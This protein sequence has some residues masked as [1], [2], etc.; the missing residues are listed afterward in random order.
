MSENIIPFPA[1]HGDAS[2]GERSLMDA[3]AERALLG[4]LLLNTGAAVYQRIAAFLVPEHFA[5]GVHGRIFDRIA[6]LYDDD[7]PVDPVI[8]KNALGE[9]PDL[10]LLGGTAH[11]IAQLTKDAVAPSFAGGYARQI[12]E[13]ASKRAVVA[14]TTSAAEALKEPNA[15]LD[16]I[17]AGLRADLDAHSARGSSLDEWDAS[18]DLGPIPPRGWL[19]GNTFCR[20]FVSSLLAD[21]GV[22]KTATRLAQC[23]AAA[24]G[25]PLTGEHVFQRCRVLIVSLEDNK[26]ELRRRLRAAMLHHNVSEEEIRGWLFLAAPGREAGKL[27]LMSFGAPAVGPLLAKLIATIKRRQ[28]DIVCIDPFVKAHGLEENSNGDI[29]F[30]VGLLAQIAIDHDC[31]VDAPHHVSK[32]SSDPGNA[33][34]GRGAGAF[35]DGGRL[36]YTLAPMSEDE[37]KLF[38]IPAKE[39]RRLI[40]IDSG[41]VNIAPPAT[42]A[43]WLRLVGVKIGNATELYP[44]GDEVHT[45]EPWMPPDFWANLPPSL[46][47]AILD[48]IDAG[49]GADRR[50]SPAPQAKDR[51]AWPVVAKAVPALNETQA[52]LV[53]KTWLKSEL[54]VSRP[55]HDPVD[56]REVDGLHVNPVKRPG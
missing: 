12:A 54:L 22:G 48:A 8:V 38:N 4:A 9:D 19:L 26:N 5:F 42:D 50:Y 13:A 30:V 24:T 46:A 33:N 20:G 28:I 31:A 1:A 16:E 56:R 55:Y 53:I 49:P 43:T 44:N 27:A 39:R 45:V 51:A 3:D 41:K 7:E 32:G 35:K 17:V 21:G 6:R 52:K 18:L 40:R 29:D 15:K 37:G 10:A 2:H 36:V 47:N 14:A 34:R 11:Y 23:L 25:R